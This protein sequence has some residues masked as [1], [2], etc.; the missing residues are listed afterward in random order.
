[1]IRHIVL[2]KLADRS[3]D[4]AAGQVATLRGALEPLAASVPG[5]LGLRVSVDPTT[6][7]THWDVALETEHASWEDLAAYQAHPEAI[8][9]ESARYRDSADL[10]GNGFIEGRS[11]LFPMYLAAAR[12]YL[13]PVFAYGTPRLARLGFEFLF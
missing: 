12:D 3:P 9:Y 6:I 1:M 13:Q 8:P 7:E 4:A 5:V 11:E 2:F 10:D